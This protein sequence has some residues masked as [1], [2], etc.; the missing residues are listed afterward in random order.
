MGAGSSS[1]PLHYPA[2]EGCSP[3]LGIFLTLPSA[4]FPVLVLK[5]FSLPDPQTSKGDF[6]CLAGGGGSAQGAP[7][8]SGKGRRVGALLLWER[9]D[10]LFS[11]K[12]YG[13]SWR[14]SGVFH[15][16]LG[17]IFGVQFIHVKKE[18]LVF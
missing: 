14:G 10:T 1:S 4:A 7:L 11:L 12:S 8:T 9:E 16:S 6:T 3:S 5:P 18:I 17:G 2:A 13:F 15:F